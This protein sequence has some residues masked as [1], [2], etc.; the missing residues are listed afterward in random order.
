MPFNEFTSLLS[1][2]FALTH[3][4]FF[5]SQT[6][7]FEIGV[8]FCSQ[9]GTC[10]VWDDSKLLSSFLWHEHTTPT[11]LWTV[12]M[13]VNLQG[14]NQTCSLLYDRVRSSRSKRSRACSEANLD[15]SVVTWHS[16]TPQRADRHWPA[17]IYSFAGC[18]GVNSFSET[19]SPNPG[20]AHFGYIH[21]PV[22][23]G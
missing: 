1:K 20:P 2:D 14:L 3:F 11:Q 15:A 5:I 13:H 18:C 9:S 16:V 21:F 8:F 10:S 4:Y 17:A 7:V 23:V 6:N 19:Q 12:N 22:A